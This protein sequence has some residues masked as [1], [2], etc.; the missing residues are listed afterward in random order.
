[1]SLKNYK[2]NEMKDTLWSH[3][4]K[5]GVHMKWLDFKDLEQKKEAMIENFFLSW[6]YAYGN[7]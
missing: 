7:V 6:T 1:M 3:S 5:L 4:W 2:Y